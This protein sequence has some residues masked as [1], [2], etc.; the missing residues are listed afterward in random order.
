MK[1]LTWN[2][3]HRTKEKSIP[4]HMAE[5]IAS[6]SPDVIVLT[7][8]VHSL[9]RK[10]FIEQLTDN[11]FSYHIKTDRCMEKIKFSLLRIHR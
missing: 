7:E 1:L 2:I 4:D 11:G 10:T 5:A 8:Y 6:L 9:S 3:N